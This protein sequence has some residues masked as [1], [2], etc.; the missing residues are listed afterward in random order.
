MTMKKCCYSR[1]DFIVKTFFTIDKD[2]AQD[3]KNEGTYNPSRYRT[4]YE[5]YLNMKF[6]DQLNISLN[7]VFE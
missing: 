5:A 4:K 7:Q 6:F 3:F 2:K 1:F